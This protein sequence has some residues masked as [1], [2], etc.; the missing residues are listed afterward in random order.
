MGCKFG[1][2]RNGGIDDHH[3]GSID[4]DRFF[5]ANGR[6]WVGLRDVGTNEYYSLGLRQIFPIIRTPPNLQGMSRGMH[7]V[8]MAVA[9]TAV[10][11]V[12]AEPGSHE[13]LKKIELFVGAAS[14][15]ET[16]NCVGSMLALDLRKSINHLVHG[17][18]P[19]GFD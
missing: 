16:G 1:H 10:Q 18:E 11:L 17:F 9:R 3:L 5:D 14:R 2:V 7:E 13:F 8:E 6:E 15:D 19:G 12:G 4:A